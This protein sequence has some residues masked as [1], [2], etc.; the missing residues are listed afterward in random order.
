MAKPAYNPYTGRQTMVEP[1]YEIYRYRST[2]MNEVDLHHHDFYE[3]YLLLRG[4]V[5]Y[6]VEN[7]IFRMRPG[8]WMLVSPL[9]LHQARI[10]PDDTYERIVLWVARPYLEGLSTPRTSLTRCFDTS[11]PTHT[12]LLRPGGAVGAQLRA[13]VERLYKQRTSRAY[14]SDLLAQGALVELLVGL[15]RMAEERSD[16]GPAGA[17]DEAVDAVLHYINEHFSEPLTLDELAA[18]FFISKYHLL[19]KFDAQVGTTVHRYILQKRLIN[20]KQ[21]LAGGVPPSQVCQYCGF[22]DYA[23]FYRAFKTEYG[24][25]PRQFVQSVR[26]AG[27]AG[28]VLSLQRKDQ[29]NSL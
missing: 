29:R 19:R 16:S 9:E 17:S 28:G 23:N 12:N 10:G 26:G 15:N 6:I 27:G 25:T 5:E 3:I 18:R 14:G 8:D 24:Q 11:V 21:L 20:A 13:E 2:Y 4:R 1:D 22:G 7:K